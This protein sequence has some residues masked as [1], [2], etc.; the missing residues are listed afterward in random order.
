M[1][2][3][4]RLLYIFL[5]AI[6]I[7]VLGVLTVHYFDE[8]IPD[9]LLAVVGEMETV[10]LPLGVETEESREALKVSNKNS[11]FSMVSDKT[12]NYQ[13]PIKLF[14]LFHVK[15]VDVKVIQKMKL[16][17][18]GEPIGIYVQTNGLLV[19]DT[20][21]IGGKDGLTYAPGENLLKSGDYILK[22]NGTVVPTIRKLNQEIQKTGKK[23]VSVTIRR[24]K[25]RIELAIR[26]VL[27]TDGTYKIGTWVREDTQGIGTLTYITEDGK[28]GTLGHGIT[29]VDTG[30]LLNLNGGELYRTKII[31]ITKGLSGEPGELQG[32]MNMVAENQIGEVFKNTSLGV[33]GTMNQEN[34]KEYGKEFLP[35]GRK[36]EIKKGKAYIYTNPGKGVGTYEIEIEK[37]RIN[38]KDNK[39]MEIRVTDSELL[40]QTGGIVQGMSGSPIIQDGKII[41]A[42]THVLVDDPARGYGIF[43]ENMLSQQQ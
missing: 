43:I 13:V 30:M 2:R 10:E 20:A 28:F 38:S 5:L 12:G 6:D 3:K 16:A 42:I 9:S 4:I 18:S 22:W 19:L 23:K 27:A 21:E 14:G 24:G 17:P 15:D 26:P 40:N 31:G 37:I 7:T 8:G 25:E 35:V 41:G 39:S 29:D 32:Y 33:F 34:E 36:Q 11:G 1:K